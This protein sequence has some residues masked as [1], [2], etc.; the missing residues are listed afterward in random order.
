MVESKTYL[1]N[2]T[3][4]HHHLQL[5][6]F[7]LHATCIIILNL[8]PFK[9]HIIIFPISHF[10]KLMK[11]NDK[12]VRRYFDISMFERKKLP[13]LMKY[14]RILGFCYYDNNGQPKLI[15]QAYCFGIFILHL[16]IIALV[17]FTY[18]AETYSAL[19]MVVQR[20]P[21]VLK[22]LLRVTHVIV[23]TTWVLRNNSLIKDF[24]TCISCIQDGIKSSRPGQHSDLF[25]FCVFS[26]LNFCLI[27]MTS[28]CL[29]IEMENSTIEKSLAFLAFTLTFLEYVKE[30]WLMLSVL[31]TRNAFNGVN[32]AFRLLPPN[33][34][35]I[36]YFRK[37]HSQLFL[38]NLHVND[39]F[40]LMITTWMVSSAL[41]IWDSGFDMIQ[42]LMSTDNPSKY[43][44]IIFLFD[45]LHHLTKMTTVCYYC[46]G[47]QEEVSSKY[48]LQ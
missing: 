16:A 1:Y 19:K 5:L 10:G 25:Y 9:E 18:N 48:K 13:P 43:M 8:L 47:V 17:L 20:L 28:C 42:L 7:C 27:F 12:F 32:Q 45:A 37:I 44:L 38:L 30:E 40:C 22:L 23:A 46:E 33:A 21:M 41:T 2:K 36:K 31:T 26:L 34:E 14:Y 15:Y 4:H 11:M 3:H 39:H 35:T 24:Y 6:I 29:I